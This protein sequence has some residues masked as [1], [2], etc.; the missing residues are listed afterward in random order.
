MANWL[1]KIL[2]P[3]MPKEQGSAKRV[4][5]TVAAKKPPAKVAKTYTATE[6]VKLPNASIIYGIAASVLFVMAF[7]SFFRGAWF[8]A[9]L[10]LLPAFCFLGF[11]LY[12]LR[13]PNS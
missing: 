12:F 8:T 13:H 6:P 4:P 10:I 3:A 9:F 5:A 2:Q 11:A 7:L 1:M